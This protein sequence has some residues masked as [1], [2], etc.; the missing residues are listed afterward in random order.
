M[1]WSTREMCVFV[2]ART[3]ISYDASMVDDGYDAPHDNA[4]QPGADV[5]MA[6]RMARV[7]R[8]WRG[9]MAISLAVHGAIAL[10]MLGTAWGV[11]AVRDEPLPVV[12]T[13]DFDHPAARAVADIDAAPRARTPA[14][15]GASSGP[16]PSHET[17][18]LAA[19]LRELER[20]LARSGAASPELDALARRFGALSDGADEALSPAASD[21]VGASFAGLVAGNATKVAYVVDASG[22]MVGRF[23]AIVD[24]VERSLLRLEPTQS[25][26]VVCFRRDGAEA[27]RGKA[28]LEPASRAARADAVRWLREKVV[29]AGRSSPLE[30]LALALRSGA[31]CVFLLSTTVTGPASHE[32]DRASL[33]ALLDRLNP[34]GGA[35]GRRRAT[36]QCIQFLEE[37]PGGTLAAIA[38]E[39]AGGAGSGYRFIPRS[40]TTLDAATTASERTD[41]DR[42]N[43]RKDRP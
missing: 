29:P 21:R 40:A 18:A 13:T 30:A 34:R 14:A 36:I 5:A 8:D 7:R 38:D 39:H 35:D 32:L 24:E 1:D 9:G 17:D 11:A 16:E 22:S 42:G 31:D 10:A 26:T 25:F 43:A 33:L 12:L 37:D 27:W 23:P 4:P 2:G 15:R 19:R 3:G 20:G 6:R 28:S 41:G